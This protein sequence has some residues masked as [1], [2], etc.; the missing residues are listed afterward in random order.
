MQDKDGWGRNVSRRTTHYID[1]ES[2]ASI[3]HFPSNICSIQKPLALI[4]VCSDPRHHK[5]RQA[6]RRTWG[7]NAHRFYRFTILFIMGNNDDQKT[8]VSNKKNSLLKAQQLNFILNLQ[9]FRT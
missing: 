8:N 1:P 2:D 3:S 6:I 9:D 7:R 4:I 5:L